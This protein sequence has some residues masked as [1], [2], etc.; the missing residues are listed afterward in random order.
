MMSCI[1]VWALG[2][3]IDLGPCHGHEAV[4]GAGLL[5]CRLNTREPDE[6]RLSMN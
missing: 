3:S 1:R 4:T 5:P 2:Q 6:R